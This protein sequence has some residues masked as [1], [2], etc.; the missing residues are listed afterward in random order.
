[1]RRFA[2]FAL[3]LALLSPP[4]AAASE[5]AGAKDFFPQSAAPEAV[6]ERL[7][8]RLLGRKRLRDPAFDDYFAGVLARFGSGREDFL[9]VTSGDSFV[10]AFAHFGGVIVMTKGMWAF[11]R[12]EKEFTAIIAHET[13]HV[14]LRHFSRLREE[15]KKTA[16]LSAPVLIAGLLVGDDETKRALILGGGGIA[17]SHIYAFTREMEHEADA[18]GI[19]LIRKTG[20]D[21]RSLADALSRLEDG[22]EEYLSTHPAISRRVAYL[23]DRARA[24]V[25]E[26]NDGD[27]G[28]NGNDDDSGLTFRLLQ[29]K[30]LVDGEV[31]GR[32]ESILRAREKSS[33]KTIRVAADYARLLLA[34]RERDSEL[35]EKARGRLAGISSHP[36]VAV[37][38]AESFFA[39]KKPKLALEVLRESAKANPE[40]AAAAFALIKTLNRLGKKAG[41]SEFFAKLPAPLNERPDILKQASAAETK[42][43]LANILLARAHFNSGE[44]EKAGR[45]AKIAE[46][47]KPPPQ[48]AAEA[49]K[50]RNAAA[51]EL[52][53]LNEQAGN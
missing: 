1:M 16:A 53:A 7:A 15:A 50:I 43:A 45:Q 23:R 8:S 25:K 40:S 39:E 51:R 47:L 31:G 44:F 24:P 37:A 49:A 18:Y 19:K 41:A 3:T 27:D 11:A 28:D 52:R 48:A 33:D 2:V 38:F 4:S 32:L 12:N 5:G 13:G 46:K 34:A 20:G 14:R 35:A 21:G 22:G 10:N 26:N 29:N 30:L 36:V 42:P 17:A 9:I 6:R